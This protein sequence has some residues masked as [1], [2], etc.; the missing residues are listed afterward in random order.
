LGFKFDTVIPV[1]QV[2]DAFG[3]QT[4]FLQHTAFFVFLTA[5]AWAGIIATNR[6]ALGH[7]SLLTL[8]IRAGL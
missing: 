4:C 1:I 3:L 5:A 2:S 6:S 7:H 8:F